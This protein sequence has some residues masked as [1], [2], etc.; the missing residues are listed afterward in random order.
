MKLTKRQ[1]RRI[2]REEKQRLQESMHDDGQSSMAGPVN[3][4]Y[5][6]QQ[7]DE[8]MEH[9]L[10]AGIQDTIADAFDDPMGDSVDFGALAEDMDYGGLMEQVAAWFEKYIQECASR[11]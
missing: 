5:I 9:D 1:L 6:Y 11:Y 7:I 2:I 8:K 10:L 4:T 3:L